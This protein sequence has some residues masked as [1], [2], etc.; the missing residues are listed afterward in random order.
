MIG[1][2]EALWYC[3][4]KHIVGH[5]QSGIILPLA[6]HYL[7]HNL[8]DKQP[9]SPQITKPTCLRQRTAQIK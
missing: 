3:I 5:L 4:V 9:I 2:I 8:N 7:T 1:I 6:A